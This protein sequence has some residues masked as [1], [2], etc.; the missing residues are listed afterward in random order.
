MNSIV[1]IS[2]LVL[3]IPILYGIIFSKKVK[4]ANTD[5]FLS[6]QQTDSLRG[7]AIIMIMYSHYY[8]LIGV[9]YNKTP[10]IAQLLLSF[11][12]IGVALFLFMSGYATMISKE[13]KTNY[14]KGYIPNRIYRLYIPFIFVFLFYVIL[15]YSNGG[16]VTIQN[17]LFVPL[18]SL[19]NTTNW[20]L[21]VQLALYI[22]F[23]ILT[24]FFKNSKRVIVISFI[25]CFV[26][27]IV[28]FLC[29]IDNFWYE[30]CY[31]FP[32]GMA[33]ALYRDNIL[34][35]LNKK[36]IVKIGL[37]FLVAGILY[38]PY[39]LYGG[40]LFE[41][42]YL[43]GITQLIICLS[44]KLL[45]NSLFLSFIGKISLEL[46]LSHTLYLGILRPTL[47][48]EENIFSYMVFMILSIMLAYAVNKISLPI[49]RKLKR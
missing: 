28:G 17:I 10:V 21:K 6:K 7:I 9:D 24:K 11:G 39:Y 35:F 45:C 27:M 40:V 43:F 8:P 5:Y 41:I 48:V 15:I 13:K 25:C 44:A 36:Y 4:L 30:S 32:L 49:I 38:I 37:S 47:Y 14:L 22:L 34:S 1:L 33:F 23:F 12:M 31:M 42:G 18:M 26:Y 2:L 29:K 3:G 19:P 20:Y 16:Q 46:Y